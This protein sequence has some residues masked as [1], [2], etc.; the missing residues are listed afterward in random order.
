[1]LNSCPKYMSEQEWFE[2]VK[3]RHSPPPIWIKKLAAVMI[4][5]VAPFIAAALLSMLSNK[6][7]DVAAYKVGSEKIDTGS[8]RIVMISDLHRKKLDETNQQVVDKTELESPDLIFVNGDMLEPDYTEAEAEA[9]RSL[10]ERLQEIAPVYFS[11]GNHDFTAFFSEYEMGEKKEFVRGIKPSPL[12]AMLESTGA[13]FLERDYVDIDLNGLNLRIGGLYA[14]AYPNT[15]YSTA[16]YSEL[17]KW[18]ADFNRTERYK[19]ILAHRPKSY[20]KNESNL[21]WPIDLILCGHSHNGVIA[22]PFGLGPVYASET[23]FSGFGRGHFRLATS[24]LIVGAGIDGY[25][26]IVPRVFNPPEIVTIDIV[27]AN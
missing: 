15:Y 23:F 18:L 9:F 21:Y 10:L 17:F 2:S 4:L 7:L 1:M 8:V 11:V 20:F 22:L 6:S 19:I 26:G 5:I 25:K 14:F 16:Q 24:D 3:K 27:P 13:R 12:I